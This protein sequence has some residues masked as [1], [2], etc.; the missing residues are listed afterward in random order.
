MVLW[1]ETH[2]WRPW[3]CYNH[4]GSINND[5]V[6]RHDNSK[7]VGT[8]ALTTRRSE[9]SSS[10]DIPLR[11]TRLRYL[12]TRFN[13]QI[14]RTEFYPSRFAQRQ[15][16]RALKCSVYKKCAHEFRPQ[17]PMLTSV[18]WYKSSA[19]WS[20]E[21]FWLWSFGFPASLLGSQ[22]YYPI[23]LA[24]HNNCLTLFAGPEELLGSGGAGERLLC[25][26]EDASGCKEKTDGV[27]LCWWEVTDQ[28]TEEEHHPT[29]RA[30]GTMQ[31]FF[32]NCHFSSVLHRTEQWF[33]VMY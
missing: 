14:C 15:M 28:C 21:H 5:E 20:Q 6:C 18:N 29:Q 7:Q 22:S 23:I 27:R 8:D 33:N 32:L 16:H 31:C 30:S 19:L 4:Y 11:R 17:T 12:S 1:G 2:G 26:L 3:S 24:V 13:R 9:S 10:K 25:R